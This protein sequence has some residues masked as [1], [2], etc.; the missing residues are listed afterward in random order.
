MWILL[1]I[2]SAFCLGCY[3]VSKKNA[4]G[5]N[6]VM[7]VLW[8][9]VGCSSLLLL[10]ML[11]ISR[12]CP[13]WLG[14]TLFYVPTV[15]PKVHLLILLKSALVLSS[16][17][18]AYIAMKHLPI[19]LVSPINAT[20]P[21]WTLLGALVLF[22]EVLNNWQWAGIAVALFSFLAFSF[23]GQKEGI[24]FTHNRYVYALLLGTFLGAASG[25]YDK[26]LMRQF[27]HNAVQVYYTVYQFLLWSAVVGI[28][29][30]V[31]PSFRTQI[32]S[33]THF[34][35]IIGISLFLV[36]SDFVYLLALSY[37]DSLISVISTVRRSG[38]VIPFLYG[39]FVLHDQH[40][41]QKAICLLGVLTGMLFLLLGTL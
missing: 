26:Y 35:W 34:G 27:D 30:I 24:R 16:W 9:S 20:R 22:G 10:P 41:K 38:V 7:L 15:E 37:P 23:V 39:V 14:G 40:A 36:L 12:F 6:H 4:L 17:F 18:F 33:I 25:L 8:L 28:A 3:D 5:G 1:A 19:T 2:V 21:M 32:G 31:R 29:M 13:E 11:L